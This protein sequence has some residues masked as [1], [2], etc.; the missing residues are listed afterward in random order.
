MRLLHVGL[1][2]LEIVEKQE[3]H[4][5][6]VHIDNCYSIILPVTNYTIPGQ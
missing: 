3:F 5:K 2:S 6:Q 1:Q 4:F